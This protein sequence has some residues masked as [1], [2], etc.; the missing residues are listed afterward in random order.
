MEE[1]ELYAIRSGLETIETF[2]R[3][4]RAVRPRPERL[5]DVERLKETVESTIG[6]LAQAAGVR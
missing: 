5:Q 1:R 6:P 2:A 4:T 3:R